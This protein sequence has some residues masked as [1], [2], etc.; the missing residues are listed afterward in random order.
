MRP[1]AP[2]CSVAFSFAA[3]TAL[4]APAHAL[5]GDTISCR[6]GDFFRCSAPTAVVGAGTEFSFSGFSFGYS[7]D[8]DATGLTIT[9]LAAPSGPAFSELFRFQDLTTPFSTVSFE[10][11]SIPGVDSSSPQVDADGLGV[12]FL[13]GSHTVGQSARLNL[14]PATP[15]IPEPGSYALMAGGLALLGWLGRGRRRQG[16]VAG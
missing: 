6:D 3:L 7:F 9:V 10:S 15:A 2:R 14:V 11:S 12:L 8:F 13:D 4:A 1:I 16:A 5:L